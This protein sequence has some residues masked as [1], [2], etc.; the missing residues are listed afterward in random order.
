[1]KTYHGPFGETVIAHDQLG[2][3]FLAAYQRHTAVGIEKSVIGMRM[4][5]TII[6]SAGGCVRVPQHGHGWI[7]VKLK[8]SVR[9]DVAT[10][11][12]VFEVERQ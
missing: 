2:E 5:A 8:L 9:F 4:L 3:D 1:M 7:G 12:L 6:D 10:M 11:D